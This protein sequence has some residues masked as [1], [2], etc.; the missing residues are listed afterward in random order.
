MVLTGNEQEET[1]VDCQRG[2][3]LDESLQFDSLV[4]EFVEIPE[5]LVVFLGNKSAGCHLEAIY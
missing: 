5:P 4:A 3:I 2:D 1:G